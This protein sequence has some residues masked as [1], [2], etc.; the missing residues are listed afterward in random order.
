MSLTKTQTS[1]V[2][3]ILKNVRDALN[4]DFEGGTEMLS[5]GTMLVNPIVVDT[6]SSGYGTLVDQGGRPASL[7]EGC[8]DFLNAYYPIGLDLYFFLENT[9]QEK[10]LDN[11]TQQ[12]LEDLT[13]TIQGLVSLLG[14][15]D[16]ELMYDANTFMN[17]GYIR[18]WKLN[19]PSNWTSS[20][21]PAGLMGGSYAAGVFPL[22]GSDDLDFFPFLHDSL[23][24][25]LSFYGVTYFNRR[26]VAP[27]PGP[28][29]T[30]SMM[31]EDI[32]L[33]SNIP[34]SLKTEL[35]THYIA[36]LE[37]ALSSD[38]ARSKPYLPVRLSPGKY[39][40]PLAG[41]W[42]DLNYKL[43][44]NGGKII[45]QKHP[46]SDGLELSVGTGVYVTEVVVGQSGVWVGFL[47]VG[48]T[49]PG[50]DTATKGNQR[51]LY[52]H[53][54]YLRKKSG[55]TSLALAH[56][57]IPHEQDNVKPNITKG[58]LL[59]Q[60]DSNLNWTKL[61]YADVYLAY[62]SFDEHNK[63]YPVILDEEGNPTTSPVDITAAINAMKNYPRNRLSEGYYYF[64]T[65]DGT[66][67]TVG[68][69]LDKM[70]PDAPGSEN[71]PQMKEA[72]EDEAMF[73][74]ESM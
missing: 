30:S 71:S 63:K 14:N 56:T 52:T 20:N 68:E 49:G 70:A 15:L 35:A 40:T 4:I 59:I 43:L 46:K 74:I 27:P 66:R 29:D 72:K 9:D 67:P 38:G 51:V 47:P 54:E 21:M 24:K 2:I 61:E 23:R 32:I 60:P 64:V 50:I 65:I 41:G 26:L 10:G 31:S 34:N 55:T 25:Y 62:Y 6:T 33:E 44:N 7:L 48:V 22:S 36:S 57:L 11:L 18:W 16:A 28:I 73:A 42:D 69:L 1:E 12:E 8:A 58:A 45:N 13:G 53:P 39:P 37:P 5:D 17:G 19:H 3:E